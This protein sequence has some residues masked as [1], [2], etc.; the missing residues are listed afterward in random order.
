M[1]HQFQDH[2]NYLPNLMLLEDVDNV[3]KSKKPFKDWLETKFPESVSKK[4]YLQSHFIPV[5]APLELEH[6]LLF[7][8]QREEELRN[9][10]KTIFGVTS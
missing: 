4:T 7:Y 2:Y 6:F 9:R 3:S 1:I 10:L 5:D 8:K